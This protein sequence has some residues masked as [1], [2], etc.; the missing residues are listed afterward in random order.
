MLIQ[1]FNVSVKKALNSDRSLQAHKA[2]Y[3]E[4]ENMLITHLSLEGI[5]YKNIPDIHRPNVMMLHMFLKDKYDPSGIFQKM[6][7]RLVVGGNTQKPETYSSIASPTVNPVTL[8]VIINLIVI[9]SRECATFDVPAAFLVPPMPRNEHF[10]GVMDEETSKIALEVQPSLSNYK[11]TSGR[12]YFRIRKYQYGL[13]QSSMKFYEY[14]VAYFLFLGFTRTNLDEC[15]FIKN[16]P[17]GRID[18]VFHVDDIFLTAPNA[19]IIQEYAAIFKKDLNVE[20]HFNSPYSFIGM[21]L[22]RDREK[23]TIKVTMGALTDKLVDKYAKD[24]AVAITPSTN[25]LVDV[26]ETGP[27]NYPLSKKRQSDF[28]SAVMTLLFI[29]RFVRPDCLF[30][31]TVLATRLQSATESDYD[32]MTRIVRYLKG[33]R[34]VGNVYRYTKEVIAKVWADASHGTLLARSIGAIIITLGSAAIVVKCWF[35]KYFSLSAAESEVCTVTEGITYILWI[36][37]LLEFFGHSQIQPT[38]IYQD[39]EAAMIMHIAGRGSFK[40]SKHLIARNY[41]IKQ[42]IDEHM[43]KLVK[44]GTLNMISDMVT[45]VM[46]GPQLRSNMIGAS[47]E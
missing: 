8:S 7:A 35:I 16:T 43:V 24:L 25:A 11:S 26:P 31:V 38:D 17:N 9:E 18:V 10:Y 46:P 14:L 45:K 33:T 3:N 36:R 30:A 41:F 13:H 1:T 32:E 6:K 29:V 37:E 19:K 4:L 47:M 39:N 28:V 15:L 5:C 2:I 22:T 40:R 44:V 23:R 34:N 21:T 42:Y 27:Q 12:I 20:Q